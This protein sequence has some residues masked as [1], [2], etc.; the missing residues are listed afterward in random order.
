MGKIQKSQDFQK[1]LLRNLKVHVYNQQK[2]LPIKKRFVVLLVK[3]LLEFLDI[4]CQEIAFYF[5]TE[6]KISI[7]HKD[8]FNDPTVTDCITFPMDQEF[9][10]EVFI[11][12]SVAI[13]YA[14]KNGLCPIQETIL[15]LVHGVLH[16]IGY[17]DLEPGKRKIMRSWEEKCLKQILKTFD[18][19]NLTK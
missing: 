5:V 3:H 16:L 12:P 19:K 14:E 15:Y 7:L 11:C 10:G 8:F 13:D 1:P 6:K 17:D 4:S 9:L 2:A 18:I